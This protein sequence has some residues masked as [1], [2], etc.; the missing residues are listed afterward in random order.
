MP[1]GNSVKKGLWI[2]AGLF[3][4]GIGGT[5]LLH[6]MNADLSW[7]SNWYVEGGGRGGW[8]YSTKPLW[9]AL[10]RYGE[11]PA[12][13]MACAAAIGLILARAGRVSRAYSRPCL[14]VILAVV[15]GPGILVN[16]LFKNCWG[17][18]RPVDVVIFGGTEDFRAVSEPAGPGG[19]KSFPCGHCAMAFVMASGVF[20]YRLHPVASA[21][22]VLGGL[23]FGVVMGLAR[24]SQ[25][26]H[27]P[28]DAWWAGIMVM[29]VIAALY[30]LVL[31]IPEQ[32][33]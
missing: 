20:F 11:Y 19:G 30:Y 9:S 1:V 33:A 15:I 12:W 17:R 14:A 23:V 25:G 16:G 18:P 28:T 2:I 4:L 32:D 13:I 27:F 29:M 10:Y 5:A 6:Q 26:G 3:L 8:I 22:S 31:K 24:M 7:T 21:C